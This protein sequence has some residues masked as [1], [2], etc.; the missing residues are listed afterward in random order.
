MRDL[1]EAGFEGALPGQGVTR[2]A[3]TAQ[4]RFDLVCIFVSLRAESK[5]GVLYRTDKYSTTEMHAL[6]GDTVPPSG[7]QT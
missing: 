2:P 6:H 5:S 4:A 7:C 1:P 3:E